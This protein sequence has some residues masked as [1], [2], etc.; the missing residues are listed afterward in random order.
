MA[1]AFG[2]GGPEVASLQDINRGRGAFSAVLQVGLRWRERPSEGDE[3]RP[4]TAVA[5]LLVDGPNGEAAIASGAC[6]RE[7]LAYSQ[8]LV[9]SPIATPRAYA[10]EDDGDR[11]AA[12]LLE[13]LSGYRAVDQVDGL[14]SADAARVANSLSRFHRRWRDDDRLDGLTVRRNTIAGL[15]ADRLRAGLECLERDWADELDSADRLRFAELLANADRLIELFDGAAATLCHGDPRADNLVFDDHD[16]VVLFDWQQIAVQFGEA[17][18]AW[19][20]ATSIEPAIRRATERD[21]V[22]AYGG[23][24]DRYRL[25]MALPGMAVLLLAQR[26]LPTQR[27]RLFVATSLRRIAAAIGDLEVAELG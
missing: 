21:L 6:G 4:A 2:D 18:L 17:D 25:G 22:A 10:I 14:D 20:A 3:H 19:L 11:G 26:E 9:D 8:L 5:K 16:G 15:P 13:D 12:F 27:A 7:V 24:F 23:D 1:K